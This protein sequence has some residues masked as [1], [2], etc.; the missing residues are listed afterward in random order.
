MFDLPPLVFSGLVILLG[1]GLYAFSWWVVRDLPLFL[2]VICRVLLA[3]VLAVPVALM[4]LFDQ[5]PMGSPNTGIPD[6]AMPDKRTKPDA[7]KRA[8]R[9]LP[10]KKEAPPERPVDPSTTD[11]ADTEEAREEVVRESLTEEE[12]DAEKNITGGAAPETGT[13]TDGAGRTRGLTAEVEEKADEGGPAAPG[14]SEFTDDRAAEAEPDGIATDDASDPTL[15]TANREKDWDVVPVYYGTD[16]ARQPNDKRIEYNANRARRLELG[17]A[18]VTVPR[19]HQVPNIERPWK[20]T[21]PYFNVTVYEEAEDPKKHFTMQEL[22]AMSED[23]LMALVKERLAK[24]ESFKDHALVFI[25]GYYTSFDLA[26][27]RTAQI[28]YDLKYDGAPF[29]YTWPSG[30]NVASYTYDLGSAAQAEP[31]LRDFLKLVAQKSGA[32]KVSIIA[33]SMG[34]Q[35]L[36]RVLQ[37]FS[38]TSPPEIKIDQLI[39]AAP[40]VDRD[41]F[42]N[43]ANSI[44]PLANGITLYAAANDWALNASQSF[45]GGVPRA[46]DVPENGPVVLSGVDTIDV[47]AISMDSLGLRHSGYAENNKLLQDIGRLIRTGERPPNIRIP[48]LVEKTTAAGL[49]WYHPALP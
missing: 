40:D 14:A 13:G 22:K 32:K 1:L 6:V 29:L 24:S 23:E 25:H 9:D 10:K 4:V 8:K 49:Y 21:I 16:R 38:R 47:T 39:L 18:L 35:V 46:G 43:I 2:K 42:L 3:I 12:A 45:H 5:L 36:L 20:V 27:Y 31:Y 17:R 48:E 28:A 7:R 11:R 26:V 30:G 33:H 44:K 41:N 34:N 37:D 15:T 19:I